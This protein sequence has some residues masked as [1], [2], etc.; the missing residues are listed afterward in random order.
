MI[1]T[2]TKI[3]GAYVIELE[4]KGDARG[5]FA[6][7]FDHDEFVR[8]GLATNF[9]QTNLAYSQ[10][11]GT[12][13]GLHYQLPPHA[14]G[15]LKRCIRGRIFD[16]MVDLRQ[17]SATYG[18]WFGVE[19]SAENRRMAYVPEGCANGYQTLERDS[20][21]LYPVTSRYAPE[22]ERGVR[23]NDPQFAIAWPVMKNLII[24]EKDQSWPDYQL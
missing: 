16:V 4:P 15:K 5:F 20:E 6:R 23:W 3:A 24:S 13:R 21:V 7:A 11:R 18:E 10:A 8:R 9:V 19:L 2:P 12:L 14:E 1:F 17:D 22:A